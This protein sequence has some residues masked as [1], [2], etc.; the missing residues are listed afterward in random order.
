MNGQGFRADPALN[1]L[2]LIM[3]KT[4]ARHQKTTVS[5][6][7][8]LTVRLLHDLGCDNSEFSNF[9]HDMATTVT[10]PIMTSICNDD[11]KACN[12]KNPVIRP[13]LA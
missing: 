5:Y 7:L 11:V 3:R 4:L 1:Q 13:K 8:D 6:A 12:Q 9:T 2:G 10:A